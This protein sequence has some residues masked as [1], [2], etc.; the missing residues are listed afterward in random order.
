MVPGISWIGYAVVSGL[1][2]LSGLWL[3]FSDETKDDAGLFNAAVMSIGLSVVSILIAVTAF[4][5]GEQWAW[6]ALWVSVFVYLAVA[7]KE[8]TIGERGVMGFYLALSVLKVIALIIPAGQFLA[9]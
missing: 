8:Y 4:R 3:I 7:W 1:V 9:S 5:A 2:V 6:F